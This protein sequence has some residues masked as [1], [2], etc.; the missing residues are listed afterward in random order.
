MH[1][2]MHT[3]KCEHVHTCLHTNVSTCT[4]AYTQMWARAMHTSSVQAMLGSMGG[5]GAG[6]PQMTPEMIK[7]AS[8]MMGSMPPEDMAKWVD[9]TRWHDKM[10]DLTTW[11]NK[12]ERLH[13]VTWQSERRR[14][15]FFLVLRCWLYTRHI[16]LHSTSYLEHAPIWGQHC[17]NR[18]CRASHRKHGKRHN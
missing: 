12:C 9:L 17:Y 15:Q 11:L 5:G 6:A 8:S 13:E 4:H 2:H 16:Q 3:H 14:R 18:K 7:M 1:A 10:S